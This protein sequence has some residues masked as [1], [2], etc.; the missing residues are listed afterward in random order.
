MYALKELNT[1][2]FAKVTCVWN[3]GEVDNISVNNRF[4]G[5]M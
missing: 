2:Y 5:R 4:Q 1:I 3:A